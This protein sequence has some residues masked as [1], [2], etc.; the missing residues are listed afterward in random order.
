MFCETADVFTV[1]PPPSTIRV[2][3]DRVVVS[4]VSEIMLED[5]AGTRK[6][7][8]LEG[9]SWPFQKTTPDQTAVTNSVGT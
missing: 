3:R 2:L 1:Q 9:L 4:T 6:K 7:E 5:F 8:K